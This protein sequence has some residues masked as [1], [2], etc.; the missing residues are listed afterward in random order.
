VS[1]IGQGLVCPT[2][3]ASIRAPYSVDSSNAR[4]MVD[5]PAPSSPPM[6]MSRCSLIGGRRAAVKQ[7][8]SEY[9]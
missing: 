7:T 2:F 3:S 5:L 9:D 6:M 1:F 8:L 4:T